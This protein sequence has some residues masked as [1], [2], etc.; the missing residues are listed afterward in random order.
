MLKRASKLL[1]QK[2]SLWFFVILVLGSLS[3]SLVMV[4]S[5]DN[6]F[7]GPNGHDGIWHVSLA[8]SLARGSWEMPT[9]SGENVKNYHIG[10][11][12]ILAL[13]NRITFIPVSV[14]YFQIIPPILALSVGILVYKFVYL[15]TKNIKACLWSLFFVYFGGS[16]GWVVTLLRGQGGGESMFWAQGAISTLVNPPF[17]LSL[18]VILAG[19]I[20]LLRLVGRFKVYDLVFAILLFG[21]LIQIKA[22]AGVLVLGGLF[23]A[24]IWRFSK[25]RKFDLLSVFLGSL[26]LQFL[27]FFPLNKSAGSL[28]VFKPFWFLETMMGLTDRLGWLK[29]GEA[30]VNYKTGGVYFKAIPAYLI[31]FLIFWYGNMGTR[32]IGE[33]EIVKRIIGKRINK[34]DSSEIN[35]IEVFVFSVILAG[36]VI[37]TFFLQA[38]TPWNTIQFFYYSLFFSGILAGIGVARFLEGKSKTQIISFSLLIVLLT[39]PTTFSTLKNDYLTARPPARISKEELTALRV[40]EKEPIGVVLT[41]NFDKVKAQAAITNPP[42]PLYLYESSSYVS[43]YT[44]KPVYMEDEVNLDITQYDW[45][46]RR[47]AV[48]QFVNSTEI[49]SAKAFLRENNIKYL[50]LVKDLTPIPGERFKLGQSQLGLT[51]LFENEKV[52]IYQVN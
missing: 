11:D 24:G 36:V 40:L 52:V 35:L 41:Y 12:L 16:F 4:R 37:P 7:W 44:G 3:W 46:S 48:D 23:V 29:F 14:L 33:V 45:R 51:T 8:R 1:S 5:G 25:D 20:I 50:Y 38:G 28:L 43:V 6:G 2:T 17:A 39:I 22:Y 15:W 18:V 21:S 9:F 10:F 42:R 34:F 47:A 30:M 27:L 31:A 32:L 26:I 13:V 19:L 49:Q